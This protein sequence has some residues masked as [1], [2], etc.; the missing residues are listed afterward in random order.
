MEPAG[1]WCNDQAPCTA[2]ACDETGA[3]VEVACQS[4]GASRLVAK[5]TE[6]W[7]TNLLKWK[8]RASGPGT[9]DFGDPTTTTGLALC[10]FDSSLPVKS[11]GYFPGTGLCHSHPLWRA[12]SA[13]FAYRSSAC[14]FPPSGI[15][16]IAVR[17]GG[18]NAVASIA[19]KAR[20]ST[21]HMPW[22]APVRVRLVRSDAPSCW[23]ATFPSVEIAPGPG[24]S[25]GV[26]KARFP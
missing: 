3:C 5:V 9:A 14:D 25:Q 8:W 22:T 17:R 1:T 15:Q 26:L 12:T 20:W 16:S 6:Y 11:A 21:P 10:T 4:A 2:S 19:F 24:S 18:P 23:E 7:D 13:G